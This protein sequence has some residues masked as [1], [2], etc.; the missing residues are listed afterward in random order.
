M[1]RD[2]RSGPLEP[3]AHGPRGDEHGAAGGARR[4]TSRARRGVGARGAP[5][6]AAP[7]GRSSRD[8]AAGSVSRETT[9]VGVEDEARGEEVHDGVRTRVP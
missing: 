7:R 6:L 3:T 5:A 9:M 8:G 4:T 2:G 1:S